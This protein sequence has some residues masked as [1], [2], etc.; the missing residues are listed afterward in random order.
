M[1]RIQGNPWESQSDL[2]GLLAP[3][4]LSIKPSVAMRNYPREVVIEV[5]H[6]SFKTDTGRRLST[7]SFFSRLF[8]AQ[9]VLRGFGIATRSVFAIVPY[10]RFFGLSG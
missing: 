2:M 7:F 6:N 1:L 10:L 5:I 9:C 3:A 4:F 8:F